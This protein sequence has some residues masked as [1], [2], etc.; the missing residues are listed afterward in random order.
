MLARRPQDFRI[1]SCSPT[2]RTRLAHLEGPPNTPLLDVT[3]D[4]ILDSHFRAPDTAGSAG[5]TFLRTAQW[6]AIRPDNGSG[7]ELSPL[8]W[9]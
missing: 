8:S 1:G 9:L 5:D 2:T 4:T 7:A 6:A 3:V